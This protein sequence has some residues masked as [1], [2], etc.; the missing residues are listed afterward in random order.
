MKLTIQLYTSFFEEKQSLTNETYFGEAREGLIA[1][2][3][4]EIEG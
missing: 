3:N 2:R 1:L 4:L